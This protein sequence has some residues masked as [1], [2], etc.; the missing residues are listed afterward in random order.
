M[1]VDLSDRIVVTRPGSG[2]PDGL[3]H[4]LW[5]DTSVRAVLVERDETG[6]DYDAYVD[7]VRAAIEL[8]GSDALLLVS[9]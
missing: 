3:A 2:S 4:L 7:E 1:S 5:W 8:T 6:A 9:S